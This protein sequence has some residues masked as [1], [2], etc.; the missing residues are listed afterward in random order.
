VTGDSEASA[1]RVAKEVGIEEVYAGLKPWDKAQLVT[2]LKKE[3]VVMFVGDGVNDAQALSA[4][5]IGVAFGTDIAKAIADIALAQPNLKGVIK[6]I[7]LS[8][9]TVSKVKQNLGWA[10]GYN[11]LLIPIAAG[12]LFKLGFVMRPEF[13]ALAMSLSSVFVSLWSR[14]V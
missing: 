10:F 3:G 11:A 9:R 6:L 5:D 13:A 8:Q 4:S 1:K 14:T 2:N 7:K 12:A